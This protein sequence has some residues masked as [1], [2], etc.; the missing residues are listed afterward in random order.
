[1]II[2]KWENI[3]MREINGAG[4]Q[5]VLKAHLK[6]MPYVTSPCGM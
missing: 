1:M 5:L 2:R 6:F 4:F 3:L